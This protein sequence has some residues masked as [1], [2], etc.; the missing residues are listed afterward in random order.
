MVV[1]MR[2]GPSGG[3]WNINRFISSELIPDNQK[4]PSLIASLL[5]ANGESSRLLARGSW[6]SRDWRA[7]PRPGGP[8][9][10][11][12][13]RKNEKPQKPVREWIRR[14]LENA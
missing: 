12:R 7:G 10:G 11:V 3:L 2:V 9:Q 5:M 4:E 13:G 1:A 14:V 8:R 6:P